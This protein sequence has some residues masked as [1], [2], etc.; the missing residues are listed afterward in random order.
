MSK[1]VFL[2]HLTDEQNAAQ[3]ANLTFVMTAPDFERALSYGAN[4]F[5]RVFMNYK[6]F[7]NLDMAWRRFEHADLDYCTFENCN[8]TGV[9]F[10]AASVRG[11]KFINCSLS[12]ASFRDTHLNY[13]EFVNCDLDGI[14]LIGTQVKKTSG[15]TTIAPVGRSGRTV[16]A[17][18]RDGKI[19]IQAGCR[20]ATPTQTRK[21]IREDYASN[22][23]Y[24]EEYLDAVKF[25]ERWGKREIARLSAA[26][27]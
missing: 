15:L 17:Y 7:A 4:A 14:T 27:E 26:N 21:A 11:A 25:L 13:T 5:H 16:Y 20:N 3:A 6:E 22:S 9:N 24:Q 19:R 10:T 23:A 1:Q 18:V 8:L 12:G 2:D